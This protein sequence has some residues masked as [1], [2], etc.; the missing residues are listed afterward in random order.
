MGAIVI[1][2]GRASWSE[3]LPDPHPPIPPDEPPDPLPPRP[4]P[5]VPTRTGT[6]LT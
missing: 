1:T 5:P 2:V 3:P 4:E 6:L